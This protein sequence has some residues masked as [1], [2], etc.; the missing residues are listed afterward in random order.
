MIISPTSNLN[1]LVKYGRD[2]LLIIQIM[3]TRVSWKK[4][5]HL[6]LK[7]KGTFLKE[8][9]VLFIC[10]YVNEIENTKLDW[11]KGSITHQQPRNQVNY[12]NEQLVHFST[13]CISIECNNHRESVD[14]DKCESDNCCKL[15]HKYHQTKKNKKSMTSHQLNGTKLVFDC[16]IDY[17][18]VVEP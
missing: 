13:F 1:L 5:I 16:E 18:I 15:K 8:C 12:G 2:S 10:V 7:M 14:C 3:S 11:R 6:L 17:I 4:I 9:T